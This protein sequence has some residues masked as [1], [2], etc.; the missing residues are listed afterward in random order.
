MVYRT[1]NNVQIFHLKWM[2]L[3]PVKRTIGQNWVE[4][5]MEAVI[6]CPLVNFSGSIWKTDRL[7]HSNRR[8]E[9]PPAL[10]FFC[11]RACIFFPVSCQ[12]RLP[13]NHI[14][15]FFQ[16]ISCIKFFSDSHPSVPRQVTTMFL[17]DYS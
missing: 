13:P 5:T 3:F 10:S 7:I 15:L 14:S 1:L 9:R 2:L 8:C 6:P 17:L 16:N 12:S 4:I 11:L